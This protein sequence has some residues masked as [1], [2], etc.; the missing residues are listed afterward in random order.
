MLFIDPI[1]LGSIVFFSSIL[2]AVMG[3]GGAIVYVPL[4]YWIGMDLTIAIPAALMLNIVTAGSASVTYIR[5]GMVDLHT[6]LPF[7]I[8]SVAGAP[9]GAYLTKFTPDN[10]I[11]GMFSIVLV[12]A[13]FLMI[14]SKN[15]GTCDRE[16]DIDP[17]G[18]I[19][20]GIGAGSVIGVA[21][22]LLGLGGGTFIV[23]LLIAIGYGIKRAP[24]TSALIIVFTSTSG[25]L[26]HL[27]STHLDMMSM[28]YMAIAALIGSQLGS[29]I[30]YIEIDYLRTM[31]E[32][33]FT[34]V[35]GL[36]L[37]IIAFLLHYST[38]IQ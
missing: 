19:L 34:K 15:D 7:I 2:F 21:A 37:I 22:G 33:Y 5:K 30:M 17:K 10:V 35:F 9:I 8:A 13:G 11:L 24:A 6:A 14:R 16:I 18:R 4:F 12:I 27:S 29:H 25:L 32:R 26:A 38:H 23:P 28:V 3:L 1:V 20:L 31:S 36:F